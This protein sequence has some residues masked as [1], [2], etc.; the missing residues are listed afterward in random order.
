MLSALRGRFAAALL[1]CVPA[2]SSGRPDSGL[3]APLAVRQQGR[4]ILTL[5]P[6][7]LGL[8]LGA[9]AVTPAH[10]I[11]DDRE[12]RRAIIDLR[13]T[14]SE[15]DTRTQAQLAALNSELLEQLAATRR[16]LLELSNEMQAMRGELARLRGDN[17]TLARDVSDVQRR[18]LDLAQN[19]DERLRRFEPVRVSL[20]GQ[21]L[22][23]EPA[24]RRAYEQAVASIRAGDFDASVNALR[25][26]QRRFP[27]SAYSPWVAF[28]LGNAL[29]GKGDHREAITVFRSFLGAA[30]QHPRAPDAMLAVANS[31]VELKDPRAAR[32]TIEDLV[33]IHPASEAAQA[34]QQRLASIR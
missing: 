7:T 16:T 8:M 14:V 17:E 6:M 19:L 20:D 1:G 12:A 24:E 2:W 29:Y 33:R 21:E 3:P 11:F 32:R 28:W 23:V 9:M 25:D 5:A 27:D 30:P 10:A 22:T 4:A 26:F 13:A 31:Q 15:N 34:G 18:Q